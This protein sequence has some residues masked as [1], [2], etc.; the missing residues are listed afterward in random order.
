MLQ[1]E[2][3]LI[4]SGLNTGLWDF[5]ALVNYAVHFTLLTLMLCFMVLTG[6]K[7][8]GR[9]MG[10]ES[11]RFFLEPFLIWSQCLKAVVSVF[12]LRS[13]WLRQKGLGV[14]IECSFCML[15]WWIQTS[16]VCTISRI[17]FFF[18]FKQCWSTCLSERKTK[19]SK[20]GVW[21]LLSLFLVSRATNVSTSRLS[22]NQVLLLSLKAV[23]S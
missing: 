4:S 13:S 19:T 11:A 18:F 6:K 5:S 17:A 10:I 23:P 20:T 21:Q 9:D 22:H 1:L 3:I 15:D 7:E 14:L 8:G 2:Y 16:L 12:L